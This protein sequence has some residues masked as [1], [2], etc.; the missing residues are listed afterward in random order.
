MKEKEFETEHRTGER[1][2]NPEIFELVTHAAGMVGSSDQQED[3][4]LAEM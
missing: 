1:E 3:V 2:K 4:P